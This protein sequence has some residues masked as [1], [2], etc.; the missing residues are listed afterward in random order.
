MSERYSNADV[1]FL[2]FLCIFCFSYDSHDDRYKKDIAITLYPSPSLSS[3]LPSSGLL[4][5]PLLLPL[6]SS[7]TT[8]TRK[9]C[10]LLLA[11]REWVGVGGRACIWLI[12]IKS[13]FLDIIFYG[14]TKWSRTLYI[15][16]SIGYWGRLRGNKNSIKKYVSIIAS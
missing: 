3:C 5:C 16:F 8:T 9:R 11:A 2:S 1:K 7:H 13:S 10:G 12:F 14:I 15:N 6:P 4:P